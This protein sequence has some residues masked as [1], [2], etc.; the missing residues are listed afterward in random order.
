M[1]KNNFLILTLLLLPF[2]MQAQSVPEKSFSLGF[3]ASPNFGWMTFPSE[4]LPSTSPDGLRTG[5][6]YG[7]L[8]D[9]A[10]SSNYYFSTALTVTSMN[11]NTKTDA[12]TAVYKLQYVE[13]PLTL[14]LKSNENNNKRFYGQFGLSADVKISAKQDVQFTDA[15]LSSI[16]NADISDNINT[17]RLGLMFGGGAEWKIGQDLHL[18]TGFTYNN[19]LTDVLDTKDKAKNSYVSLNLGVFF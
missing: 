6:S 19:G 1:I 3:T 5:F 16:K 7:V 17:F 12:Y 2:G 18:L 4:Q 9:F 13:I 15:T 11:A 14:K 10:F 8:G